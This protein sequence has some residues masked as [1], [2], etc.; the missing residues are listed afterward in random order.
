M[1]FVVEKLSTGYGQKQIIQ[2]L[3]LSF[4]EKEITVILGA[5]GSGK[6]TLLKALSRQLAIQSGHIY[7]HQKDINE[8]RIK[9]FA[10]VCTLLPQS[11]KVPEGMD[12][13]TLVSKGRF[14]HRTRL[15]G[16]S[17][18]DHQAIQE[19]MEQMGVA[20]LA[21]QDVWALSGGQ[22]QRVWIALALASESPTLL[23]DEPTTYLDIAY[24]VDILNRLKAISQTKQQT[25]V[26]VLH[27]LNLA[28]R[29]GTHFVMMKSGQVYAQGGPEIITAE[30]IKAVYGLDCLI[31]QDPVTQ[32]PMVVPY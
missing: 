15:A 17:Q 2:H 31:A 18:K 1:S 4:P 24:Q 11:P 29:F 26:V 30:A 13:K 32:G 27:D 3:D 20:S 16:L 10:Q 8:Y 25:M 19:A 28:L 6:S 14:M 23:L 5:N 7:L 12:V 22:R 9:A 21:Q